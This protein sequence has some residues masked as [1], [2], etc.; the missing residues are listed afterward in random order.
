MDDPQVTPIPARTPPALEPSAPPRDKPVITRAALE[1][2]LSKQRLGGYRHSVDTDELD[3]VARYLW[4]MALSS[5]LNYSGHVFEVTLRNAIYDASLKIVDVSLLYLPDINCWL[6][7]ETQ[8]AKKPLLY[9][10]E[11]DA[12]RNAKTYLG[13]DL[14]QRTPGHL[15]S[16]LGLGFW[17]QLTSSVYGT[18]RADGPKLWPPGLKLAFP[19]KYPAPSTPTQLDR[20]K[21][22]ERLHEIREL[23]NK[24]AHHEPIWDRDLAEDYRMILD[25]LGWMNPGMVRA[26]VSQDPFPEVLAAG[27][28]PFR[29]RA[30]VLINGRE[31]APS[32]ESATSTDPQ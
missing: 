24:I 16:K 10:K 12:V 1:R 9:A 21:V 7:A 26:V 2:A 14:H 18:L 19:S 13:Q 31:I 28:A 32:N 15:I 8:G 3:C 22:F 6:D 30:D 17:V 20:E 5:A 11:R 23:R 4:N 25:T 29:I 27:H